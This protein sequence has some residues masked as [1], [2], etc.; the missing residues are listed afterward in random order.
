MQPTD[1]LKLAF[2]AAFGPGHLLP[3][4]P[5][6]VSAIE[7]EMRDAPVT[8]YAVEPIGG[9]FARLYLGAAREGGMSASE[10][11]SRFLSASKMPPSPELFDRMLEVLLL[12]AEQGSLPFTSDALRLEHAQWERRGRP[13][14]R[15]SEIYR[16]AYAPAYRLIP[17]EEPCS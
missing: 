3:D 5:S 13:L 8:P 9:G 10:I 16:A 12:L 14:F 2:Q 17:M 11:G 15:H 4:L 6:A 1:A 7:R